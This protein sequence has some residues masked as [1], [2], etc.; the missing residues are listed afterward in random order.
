MYRVIA[1]EG[2]VSEKMELFRAVLYAYELE[3]L[4]NDKV[5]VVQA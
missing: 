5:R 3:K 2:F 1:N 4:G